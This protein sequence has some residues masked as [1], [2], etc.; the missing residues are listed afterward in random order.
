MR[1][2]NL[3]SNKCPQCNSRLTHS[4]KIKSLS[5]HNCG[6]KISEIAFNRVINDMVEKELKETEETV[7][8]EGSD[9]TGRNKENDDV[10]M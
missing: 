9:K 10:F 7:D 4:E 8:I 6:F 3:R 2:T 1:W 5:C